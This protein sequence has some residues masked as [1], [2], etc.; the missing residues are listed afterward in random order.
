MYLGLHVKCPLF[1]SDINET[2]I[3][4]IDFLKTLKFR[5]NPSSGSRFVPCGQLDGRTDR[6][7]EA[8]SRFS[9]FCEGSLKWDTH[10]MLRAVLVCVL[11]FL[12]QLKLQWRWILSLKYRPG[13]RRSMICN[14]LKGI[15][16]FRCIDTSCMW[17]SVGPYIAP[18]PALK[19]AWR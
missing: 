17:M 10:F 8:N 3:F 5:E 19:D 18:R 11:L 14:A 13:R 15:T 7:Y 4:S 6:H 16:S 2:G 12:K 1:L 9:Q